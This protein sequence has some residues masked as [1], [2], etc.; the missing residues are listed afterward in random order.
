[1]FGLW[2]EMFVTI[3]IFPEI[4]CANK[5]ILKSG[6]SISFLLPSEFPVHFPPVSSHSVVVFSWKPALS[7]HQNLKQVNVK[8]MS[9][10]NYKSEK[11]QD[12]TEKLEYS[13]THTS[14][15]L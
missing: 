15:L 10:E 9:I 7:V 5:Q 12:T 6:L 13:T 4:S 2:Y 3:T 14:T 1:M 8:F 11:N